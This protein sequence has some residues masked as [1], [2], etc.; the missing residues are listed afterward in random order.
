MRENQPNAT[1]Y[2]RCWVKFRR[3]VRENQPNAVY[4][5]QGKR[6]RRAVWRD[7]TKGSILVG[8][9]TSI[10]NRTFAPPYFGG[11]ISAA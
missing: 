2:W 1:E 4:G 10:R 9:D 6:D 11:C 7:L 3:I 5:L 8:N